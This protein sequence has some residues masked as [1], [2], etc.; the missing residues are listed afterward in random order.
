MF[1]THGASLDASRLNVNL[2]ASEA[3]R[4]FGYTHG[5]RFLTSVRGPFWAGVLESARDG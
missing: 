2:L 3:K 5:L 1:V 4:E